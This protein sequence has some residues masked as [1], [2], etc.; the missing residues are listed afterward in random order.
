[1]KIKIGFGAL[2]VLLLDTAVG[3][4]GY[5]INVAAHSWCPLF[6]SIVDFLFPVCPLVKWLICHQLTHTVITHTFGFL[7]T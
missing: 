6:W 7:L 3:M 1:M 2:P 4:L 5:N